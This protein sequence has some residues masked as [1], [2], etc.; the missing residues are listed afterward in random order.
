M[1]ENKYDDPE[2]FERYSGMAR[3]VEGLDG[4]GEWHAFRKLFPPLEGKAV[5]DLGCGYGW[6]C[7]YAADRGA[8]AVVGADISV[9][10]LEEARKRTESQRIAYVHAAIEDY[11][12]PVS[13]YDLVIGSLAFHY[14]ADFA[15]I[16]RKIH[17]CLIDGGHF[18]FSVEH[19]V[20]TAQGTQ[21]WC[22]DARG[23]PLHWPVDRYFSEG[24]R[25]AQFL[26]S[27]V[28]KYHRT[29]TTYVTVLLASGFTLT[30]LVEPEPDPTMLDS[31]PE[32][33]NE[34]RRPMMLLVSARK[35]G[36]ACPGS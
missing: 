4:A 16:C 34:L 18:V 26:G 5:L 13:A 14:L 15:G 32:M 28:V 2:F 6:H 29:L 3:S 21:D 1:R 17:A 27:P 12:F 25:K 36:T 24:I 35:G 30:A 10:M 23:E 7:R 33:R 8:R 9:L 22:R 31:V 11:A 19:P 20:F